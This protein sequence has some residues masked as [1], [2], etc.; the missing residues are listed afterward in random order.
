M[1][2]IGRGNSSGWVIKSNSVRL[3]R[4]ARAGGAALY[5]YYDDKDG[6]AG[7]IK[8]MK[9]AIS[10]N[11]SYFNSHCMMRRYATGGVHPVNRAREPQPVADH[12]AKDPHHEPEP[13]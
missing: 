7:W 5:L 9:G 12:A 6:P 11:A 1:H 4:Q 3:I 2:S 10:K 8:V 13:T